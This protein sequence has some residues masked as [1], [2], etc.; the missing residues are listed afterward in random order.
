M[1]CFKKVIIILVAIVSIVIPI[2]MSA[3]NLDFSEDFRVTRYYDN[4]EAED[5]TGEIKKA[6]QD[7][8]EEILGNMDKSGSSVIHISTK[9]SD[10]SGS[11]KFEKPYLGVYTSNITLDKAKEL[12]YTS[13]YYGV[14]ITGTGSNSPARLYRIVNNDILMSINGTKI[15]ND[16]H[17]SQVI[18]S[19]F[20]GDIVTL[21]LFRDG[22]V[23]TM[24]VELGSRNRR[25][26]Q[27]GELVVQESKK[28]EK[29]KSSVGYGGGTWMPIWFAL[30]MDDV[31]GLIDSLNFNTL[32]K[33]G[34][35]MTGGGGKIG[36]GKGYFLGLTA[37]GYDI[38]RKTSVK[39]GEEEV[40][41][42]R[43]MSYRNKFWGFTLDKR[44]ALGSKIIFSPGFLI[45][46]ASQNLSISQTDGDYDWS[47]L[48]QNMNNNYN[49]YASFSKSYILVQ[50]R[51]ELMY[52]LL[53]WLS[54]RAEGGY[55][56]GY[57]LH[58]DWRTTL[59][60]DTFETKNSPNT[61]YKGYSLSIGPWFG[62]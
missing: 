51:V 25:Y 57:S 61:E 23:L 62:F 29:K 21:E 16:K 2:K 40:N 14:L 44:Y 36:V 27:S 17:L 54:L 49:S 4:E 39:V 58:Q 38:N 47:N 13:R 20:V 41:V 7:I 24:D 9:S 42:I 60:G 37:A 32:D 18:E 48:N 28:A 6:I 1:S 52:R 26:T 30:N 15:Q 8:R 33:D 3:I 11:S 10:D 12:E 50:P 34:I 31:N 35:F 56:Y 22:K 55:L 43:R 46:G 59:T 53:S 45:G 19:Y 5:V